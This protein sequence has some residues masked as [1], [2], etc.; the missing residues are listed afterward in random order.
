MPISGIVLTLAEG[1]VTPLVDLLQAE[2]TLSLGEQVGNQLPA[3]LETED[4]E[5]S[6]EIHDWL[7]QLPGVVNVDVV[8]VGLND[9]E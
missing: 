3:V 8:F 9:E 1:D 7:F 2:P 5:Q 4:E 6:N